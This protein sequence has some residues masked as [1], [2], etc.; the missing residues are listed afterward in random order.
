[1]SPRVDIGSDSPALAATLVEFA[2]GAPAGRHA[3]QIGWCP[4]R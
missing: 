4:A 2:Q 1:V 3:E